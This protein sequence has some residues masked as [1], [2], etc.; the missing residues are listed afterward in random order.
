MPLPVCALMLLS[1]CGQNAAETPKLAILPNGNSK[2]GHGANTRNWW[3]LNPAACLNS[4]FP[5]SD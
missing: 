4:D 1:G 3:M 5:E 2:P